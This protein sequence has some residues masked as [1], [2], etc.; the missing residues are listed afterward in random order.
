MDDFA[1]LSAIPPEEVPEPPD[2]TFPDEPPPDEPLAFSALAAAP[3]ALAGAATIVV[4][5]SVLE[6]SAY[7]APGSVS[8]V[9][10]AADTT[11]NMSGSSNLTNLVNDA[12]SVLFGAPSGDATQPTAWS[13]A[14]AS[15]SPAPA[16]ARPTAARPA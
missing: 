15:A 7:T 10:L 8:N 6:G 3:A 12:S 5:N 2:E 4:R 1:P 13:A 14:W 9:T 16:A 11:W